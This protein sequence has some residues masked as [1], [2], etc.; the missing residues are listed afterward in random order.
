MLRDSEEV[1][2]KKTVTKAVVPAK[3]AAVKDSDD[4][5]SSDVEILKN[6][7]KRPVETKK[8]VA[9][10]AELFLDA[11]MTVVASPITAEKVRIIL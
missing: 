5:S 10:V 11:V 6:K 8:P 9:K 1:K 2:P 4:D 7:T 3:K